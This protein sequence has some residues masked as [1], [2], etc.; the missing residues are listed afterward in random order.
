MYILLVEDDPGTADFI[1]KGL[2]QQGNHVETAHDGLSGK[3]KIDENEYDLVI[4]DVM[5]P[6]MNGLELC[7]HIRQTKKQLPV[8]MLSVLGS[9][10][11][12][13]A[14]LEAGADDYLTKPFHF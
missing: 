4:L 2:S 7:K 8:L 13:V 12:K 14:G 9:T 1:A 3:T 5:L 11:D 10:Q 6:G